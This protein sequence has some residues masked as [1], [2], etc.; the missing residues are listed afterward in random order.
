MIF[1][2]IIGTR[3]PD[4]AQAT[5]AREAAHRAVEHGFTVRTGAAVGVDEC[6][7]I[8]THFKNLEV[9]LP[10]QS[11][12]RE[13]I[14]EWH[15]VKRIVYDKQKHKLWTRSVSEHHPNP[16]AL[17]GGGVALHA[18]NFGIVA[19]EDGEQHSSLVVAL[20]DSKGAGGT[21]QGIRI[22]K[23]LNIQLLQANRGKVMPAFLDEIFFVLQGLL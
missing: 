18:R 20:P 11:Y 23:S 16:R 17:S 22:A 1:I 7:M 13:L 10:W 9:Y 19:G 21:A 8:G 2:S 3:E 4:E 6:A 14:S 5:A 12:N 15:A